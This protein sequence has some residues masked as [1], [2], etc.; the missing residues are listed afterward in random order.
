RVLQREP[1]AKL[2]LPLQAGGPARLEDALSCGAMDRV[3]AGWRVVAKREERERGRGAP[4][5]GIAR[6]A[7]HTHPLPAPGERGARGDSEARACEMQPEYPHN[8][9]YQIA[10]DTLAASDFTVH[11]NIDKPL[12]RDVLKGA[13]VLVLLHPCD[14]KWERTTSANSPRL[15]E[16]EIDDI[17]EF[18]R[19]GGGLLVVSEYEHDK[20]GDNLNDLLAPCGLYIENTT[21]LDTAVNVHNNPAWFFAEP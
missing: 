12:L 21:V 1:P 9:S 14:P 7:G 8:S 16:P 11:R 6:S 3:A 17:R 15:S 5:N 2:S 13:D 20:Y 19:A 10:A 18:V 4:G